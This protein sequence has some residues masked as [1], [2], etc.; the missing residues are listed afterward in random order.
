MRLM[1]T[2][3]CPEAIEGSAERER[4][5]NVLLCCATVHPHLVC[6]DNEDMM[7]NENEKGSSRYAPSVEDMT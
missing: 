6:P 1:R 2:I 4:N 7:S 3:R 5:V